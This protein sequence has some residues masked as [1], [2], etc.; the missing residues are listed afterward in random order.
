MARDMKYMAED[1]DQMMKE[2][3]AFC[4]HDFP[5]IIGI[6]ATDHFT[7]SFQKQGFTDK[8]LSKWQKRDVD[9]HPEKYSKKQ[10]AASKG[11]A[12][13][14]KSGELSRSIT[15]TTAPRRII[16]KADKAYAQVHN[17]GGRAGRGKGFRM[18]KRQFMGPSTV[19]D[20]KIGQKVKISLDKIFKR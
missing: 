17:E 12:I 7:E 15:F 14:V 2:V 8:A 10:I 3:A 18:P 4:D 5:Q 16:I 19:L 13:L 9:L 6:E 20:E 11:R 1:F